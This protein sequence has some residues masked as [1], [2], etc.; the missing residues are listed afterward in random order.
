M[1]LG[2][3]LFVFFF[4][5]TI[6]STVQF[7]CPNAVITSNTKDTAVVSSVR[8]VVSGLQQAENF[9]LLHNLVAK[10][11][12]LSQSRHCVISIYIYHLLECLWLS[13]VTPTSTG[14]W[15]PYA[16]HL[17]SSDVQLLEKKRRRKGTSRAGALL[18]APNHSSNELAAVIKGGRG[19]WLFWIFRSLRNRPTSIQSAIN[20]A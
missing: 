20:P 8:Q 1:Q 15:Y 16:W 18:S 3:Y 9:C 19:S 4:S 12:G 13:P 7:R 14:R 17:S 5:S 6:R 2:F 10:I 11:N